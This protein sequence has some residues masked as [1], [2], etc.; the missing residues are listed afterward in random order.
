MNLDSSIK[1]FGLPLVRSYY[2]RGLG[3]E[4][5]YL[6]DLAVHISYTLYL[7]LLP[8]LR[9]HYQYLC[10]RSPQLPDNQVSSG[11]G[12]WNLLSDI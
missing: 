4:G 5:D 6:R 7:P 9:H 10:L 1:G 8:L 3:V 12:D 2:L 11:F